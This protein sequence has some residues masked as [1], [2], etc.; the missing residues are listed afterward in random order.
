MARSPTEEVSISTV[1]AIVAT[2]GDDSWAELALTR[3]VPS[4][5]PIGPDQLIVHHQAKANV[6][7]SRNIAAMAATTD[8]LLFLDA[9]D[10]LAP[11][12][13]DA[14]RPFM[15]MGNTDCLLAPYVIYVSPEGVRT[16]PHIPNAGNWPEHNDSVTATMIRRTTF[17]RLGGWHHTYWPWSD[18]ELWLRAEAEGVKRL[19][20]PGAVYVAHQTPGG[21]NSKI[22]QRDARALHARVKKL[23]QQAWKA[24]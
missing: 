1:A 11:G 19:H 18:W 8:W 16:T 20:V 6:C 24:Q 12:Y 2:C 13:I 21:E 10:E 7:H 9:D 4:V 22:K 17:E 5:L 3:A 23:H 14:M 15:K